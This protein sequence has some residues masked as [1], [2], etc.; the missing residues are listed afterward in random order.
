MKNAFQK[1]LL[2][3]FPDL[4]QKRVGVACSGGLDSV[5]LAF[6]THQLGYDISLLHCNFNLRGTESDEDAAFVTQL[7]EQYSVR[8]Y[9]ESFSTETYATDHKRSIQMAARELR[10]NW[11]DELLQQEKVD[12]ILTAH[13]ADDSLETFLIN[14]GRGTGLRGLTGIPQQHAHILRPLLPFSRAEILAYAKEEGLYWRE[15]S[16]NAESKYLRNALRHKVVPAWKE[17][18]P[19]LLD[20][21]ATTEQRLKSA[22]ALIEDYMTL[23]YNLVVTQQADG[24]AL[25]IEKLQELPNTRAL[26]YELLHPFGFTAWEDI[27]SLLESQSGKQVFSETHRLL[28]D[29]TLLLLT[30]IPSEVNTEKTIP[31]TATEITA[32]IHLRFTSAPHF[33]VTNAHTVFVD[34]EHLEFPLTLRKW[35]SGDVFYPFGMKGKKKLSKFFKDEKLSLAEKEQI[36]VLCSEEKI[37]WVVSQRLDERFKVTRN[38]TELLKITRVL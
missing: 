31:E 17:I 16:S 14:A 22:H 18:T 19:N 2:K 38:T 33:E 34:K 36:W 20:A 6:L 37:V 29:R 5:T 35:R 7:A 21:I 1:H 13:H 25:S 15:D 11:F 28:K 27:Y 12:F 9:H 32:P 3:T 4:Y 30:E 26:L 8:V 23:V 24:Y 10:Y